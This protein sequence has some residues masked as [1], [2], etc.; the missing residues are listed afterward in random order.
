MTCK[1]E[2]GDPTLKDDTISISH[3]VSPHYWLSPQIMLNGVSGADTQTTGVVAKALPSSYQNVI[4]VA[5]NVLK[6]LPAGSTGI[7]ASVYACLP[8]PYAL[9]AFDAVHVKLISSVFVDRNQIPVGGSTSLS[10]ANKQILWVVSSSDTTAPDGPGHKC[11]V[12][13][14]CPD[15]YEQL[16][17]SKLTGCFHQADPGDPHY[18]QLNIAIE[19]GNRMRPW[20]L[21]LFTA[22]PDRQNAMPAT[23]RAEA[24]IDPSPEVI[25]VLL[26]ALKATPGF[27]RV[28]R[29]APKSFALQLPDFPHAV[30][31]NNTRWGLCGV[32]VW[33][34]RLFGIKPKSRPHYTANV[35]LQPGQTTT[36]NVDADLSGS[37]AGDAHIFHVTHTRSDGR[38]IGGMTLVAVVQ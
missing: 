15:I 23:L 10:N 21:S 35:Q 8:G 28:S 19:P 29:Y 27:R 9:N 34:L 1:N 6:D 14:V 16:S 31:H 30:V 18:A 24:D 7:V 4:D 2:E 36:V 17:D 5:F 32:V 11:L 37:K 20:T 13:V 33:L 38:T 12:A 26:P 22:N 3:G 25:N